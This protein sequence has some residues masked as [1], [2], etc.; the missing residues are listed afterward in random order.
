MPILWHQYQEL[1]FFLCP[2]WSDYTVMAWALLFLE[3]WDYGKFKLLSCCNSSEVIK[4]WLEAAQNYIKKFL[5]PSDETYKAPLVNTR[6]K[7]V[8]FIHA[9]RYQFTGATISFKIILSTA[10]YC[11]KY[12]S[13]DCKEVK[14]WINLATT[15]LLQVSTL[16]ARQESCS[17]SWTICFS[18]WDKCNLWI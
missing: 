5:K 6:T 12:C 1:Y 14:T 9:D 15:S 16:K 10:H 11:T 13:L 4:K 2:H 18:I 17:V 8:V 3:T 7:L